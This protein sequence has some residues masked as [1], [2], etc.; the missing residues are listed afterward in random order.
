MM[1]Y[2]WKRD[3]SSLP[4]NYAQVLEK[5]EFNEQRFMKQPEHALSCDMQVK[6]MEEMKFSR[7]LTEKEESKWKGPVHYVAHPAVLRPE[8]KSTPIRIVLNSSASF[9]GHI[10]NDCWFKGPDLLNNLFGVVF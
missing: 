1:K 5:L 4:N 6:E 8:K 7:K 3:P 9:K 10:L 2:P